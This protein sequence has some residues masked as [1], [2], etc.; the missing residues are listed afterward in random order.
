M[1]LHRCN[2]E[3]QAKDSGLFRDIPQ[4]PIHYPA[5]DR[6]QTGGYLLIRKVQ[7]MVSTLDSFKNGVSLFCGQLGAQD[8]EPA[9]ACCISAVMW[10]KYNSACDLRA[11]A[12]TEVFMKLDH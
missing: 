7:A 5:E 10:A 2:S 9:I 11:S 12:M 4:K 6:F 3:N 1:P 8:V